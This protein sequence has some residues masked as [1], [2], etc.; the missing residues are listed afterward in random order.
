M[1]RSTREDRE[2]AAAEAKCDGLRLCRK[3]SFGTRRTVPTVPNH[4]N[5]SVPA[6]C[7]KA[8][9]LLTPIGAGRA[10]HAA[11][12]AVKGVK[13]FSERGVSAVWRLCSQLCFERDN[14]GI[15]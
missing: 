1:P 5:L 2:D 10:L 15:E 14:M 8:S 9:P 7:G 4:T 11:P 3:L 13:R 12:E 6:S